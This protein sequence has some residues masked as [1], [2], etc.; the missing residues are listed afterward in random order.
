MTLLTVDFKGRFRGFGKSRMARLSF[1][2]AAAGTAAHVAAADVEHEEF[3]ERR[4][5]PVLAEN[6]YE[7]HSARADKPKAGLRLDTRQGWEKGGESGPAIR[8]G[9]PDRSLL[10]RAVRHSDSVLR[11]PPPEHAGKLS[12]EEIADLA[13]WVRMGAPDPRDEET[14]AAK[15]GEAPAAGSDHWSLQPPRQADLPPVK[16]A[17]W[18]GSEIDR[19]ILA[20]LEAHDLEPNPAAEPRA[21]IR[22]LSFDLTGL[23]PRPEEIAAFV[24][25]VA[26]DREAAVGALVDRLL[27]SP[28]FGERWARHW[29]DVARFAESSGHERNFTYPH[30]WRY[31]DWVIDSFNADK[32]YDRFLREQIAGDLLPSQSREQQV[33]QTLGTAFLALGSKNH[34]TGDA[35]KLDL[36]DD[37]IDTMSKAVLGLTVGCARCHDHK[38][39]PISTEDYYALAGIFSS[40]ESL[41]G[42]IE[43][44]GAGSN[45]LAAD[46]FVV[47]GDGEKAKALREKRGKE[48]VEATGELTRVQKALVAIP[49]DNPTEEETRKI[50][51]LKKEKAD[52][53]KRLKAVDDAPEPDVDYAMAARNAEKPVDVPVRIKGVA[54]NKGEIVPRGIPAALMN[55]EAPKIDP[56][57]SGRLELAEWL[58]GEENP[59]TSR[60]MVNRIWKHLFG[61][62]LVST[63]DNFGVLGAE[64]SHPELLDYLAVRFMEDGWSTKSMIR[65]IATSRVYQLSSDHHEANHRRDPDAV[66]LWR[67]PPRRL[68]VEPLRD[69][70]LAFGGR[71][72]LGPPPQGSV[73]AELGDGCL[74]RQIKTAPL[75]ESRRWRSVYLPVVRF[76]APE[77]NEVFDGAPASLPLGDRAVTTVPGQALFLLNNDFVVEQAEHAARRLLALDLPNDEERVRVAFEGALGREPDSEELREATGFVTGFPGKNRTAAWSAFSQALFATAE[78]RYVY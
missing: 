40:T 23:P 62:G 77:F 42:T 72:E 43:G 25:A 45:R 33:D 16:E 36:V 9:N 64:P 5:R 4:I 50:A 44:K 78:F 66:R 31:R 3:F 51:E 41:H 38:Y 2:A 67:V 13:Q 17:G 71:L 46:L 15:E 39:D 65:L 56:E 1:F 47:R 10:V 26:E 19:F 55:G 18:P 52:I 61:R 60:V 28:H 11:M 20:D 24:E 34:L 68:E 6:C 14:V 22:R 29:L 57:S 37:Q 63:V 7:C 69:A 30:A 73:V 76:Y 75:A 54:G 8:P 58:A 53:E 70:M 48:R 74:Q 35:D 27:D 59:L 32:P 21:L 49:R 12:S